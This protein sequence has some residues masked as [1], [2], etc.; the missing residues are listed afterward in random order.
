MGGGGASAFGG[1]AGRRSLRCSRHSRLGTSSPPPRVGR[2][3]IGPG[4]SRAGLRVC[5]KC[6]SGALAARI[7]G[8]RDSKDRPRSN[9]I[10]RETSG[11]KS[12][13]GKCQ[14]GT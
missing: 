6:R 9:G 14:P 2:A 4:E 5:V 10:Q 11:K 13:H 12:Q 1:A 3:G 7:G 8:G